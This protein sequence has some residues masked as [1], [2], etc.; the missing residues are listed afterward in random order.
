MSCPFQSLPEGSSP[1]KAMPE[2]ECL[3]VSL[4]LKRSP[5]SCHTPSRSQPCDTRPTLLSLKH[6]HQLPS[7]TPILSLS[8]SRLLPAL[9]GQPS[10]RGSCWSGRRAQHVPSTQKVL[11]GCVLN[12]S[13][14]RV[15]CCPVLQ[16]NRGPEGE[17]DRPEAAGPV[18]EPSPQDSWAM[19]CPFLTQL[20]QPNY[21]ACRGETVE[22]TVSLQPSLRR[23]DA[24]KVTPWQQQVTG[25]LVLPPTGELGPCLRLSRH[26]LQEATLIQPG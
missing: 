8:T 22:P 13:T 6:H 20:P 12:K 16:R 18:T 7:T 15:G 26:H 2:L 17:G 9:D 23:A 4:L 3:Q 14:E 24:P 21:K 19:P 1:A 25:R 11:G 5:L 10:E